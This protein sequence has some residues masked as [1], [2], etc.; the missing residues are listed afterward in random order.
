MRIQPRLLDH[1]FYQAWMKGDISVETLSAYHRSYLRLITRIPGFWRRV[2]KSFQP[3]FRGEHSI[4][5]DER[6]H[7]IL[8]KAWGRTLPPPPRVHSLTHLLRSLDAMNPSELLGALQAFEIQQPEVAK[9]KKAGLMRHYGFRASDLE[10][11][12]EHQREAA[13]IEFGSLLARDCAVRRDFKNG[14]AR[15]AVLLYGSLDIF[16]TGC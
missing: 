6:R 1:P 9:T 10:Y 15:G 13:H 11:F 12:D 16:P 7:V 14:M 4:V 8:W 3:G 2:L 5:A